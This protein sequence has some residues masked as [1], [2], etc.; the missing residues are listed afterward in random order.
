[1]FGQ[2][3]S[4]NWLILMHKQSINGILADEMG[5]GK[6]IQTI[7]FLAHLKETGEEGPN[8]I[9]VPSSTM[10]RNYCILATVNHLSFWSYFSLEISINVRSLLAD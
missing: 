7:S 6:T 10:G 9:I 8:L 4:L 1:M 3:F 2:I 5:L